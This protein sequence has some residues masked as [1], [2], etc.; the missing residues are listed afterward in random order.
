MSGSKKIDDRR[1]ETDWCIVLMQ[2]ELFFNQIYQSDSENRQTLI[3][4]LI[5]YCFKLFHISWYIFLNTISSE[6]ILSGSLVWPKLQLRMIV[7]D[8]IL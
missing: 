4:I 8:K 1:R 6:S 5:A 2:I 7:L 3:S